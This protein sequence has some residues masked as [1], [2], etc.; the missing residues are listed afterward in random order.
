MTE[1]E[2][3]VCERVFTQNGVRRASAT[4]D[5][6]EL[7]RRLEAFGLRA[8]S[9]PEREEVQAVIGSFGEETFDL[10]IFSQKLVPQV[11]STLM[12]FRKADMAAL[13]KGVGLDDDGK[14]ML[15][16][17]LDALHG[18][19][20]NVSEDVLNEAMEYFAFTAGQD[21]RY[22]S[23][24][25]LDVEACLEFG[26]VLQ[27]F[28]S[29]AHAERFETIVNTFSLS[30][31][32]QEFWKHELVEVYDMFHVWDPLSGKY[33]S[34]SGNLDEE[35][36]LKVLRES[37]YM[38]KLVAEQQA[39]SMRVS[40]AMKQGRTCCF[41]SFL[42]ILREL[43]AKHRQA[44]LRTIDAK[45][46]A[47]GR[48]S[49]ESVR[50]QDLGEFLTECGIVPKTT[51]ERNEIL[52]IVRD[53]EGQASANVL[54]REELVSLCQRIQMRFRQLKRE[55]E[56]QFV[57]SVGWKEETVSEYRT[58]FHA[59]DEDMSEVLERD[60][61]MAAVEMLKGHCW[62]TQDSMD[63]M[64]QEVGI[65]PNGDVRLDFLAFLRMMKVLNE[66]E[67]RRALGEELGFTREEV[68]KLYSAFKDFEVEGSNSARK[69]VVERG[70]ASAAQRSGL[71][72]LAE[73]SRL[74]AQEPAL[75][76]FGPILRIAAWLRGQVGEER[77]EGMVEEWLG[78]KNT[79]E[80]RRAA[81]ERAGGA[82]GDA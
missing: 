77:F 43:R 22:S 48:G 19:G 79:P 53:A 52:A 78:W 75:I 17:L 24:R 25:P 26:A 32:D 82:D 65:D 35:Q 20:V 23:D 30:A 66:G 39:V 28:V 80:G 42:H 37:G 62:Q 57:L 33:G 7:M 61:L 64:F 8:K 74:F 45:L 16:D 54:S 9:R 72:R 6:A 81:S 15:G 29:R 11:R 38:P 18:Q 41:T 63:A 59:L 67:A 1:V 60:E 13:F 69:D 3:A 68:D 51:A 14:L 27:E 40:T 70:L 2:V 12:D 46:K 10:A 5:R 56:R 55:Q 73:F 50:P 47:S 36:M 4:I 44:L 49:L 21:L 76:E 31:D 34:A 71:V 58:V